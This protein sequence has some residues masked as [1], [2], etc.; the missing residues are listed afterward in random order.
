MNCL[1]ECIKTLFVQH[2]PKVFV[3]QTVFWL[4]S[5]FL[6]NPTLVD[7]AWGANHLVI[8]YSIFSSSGV[9]KAAP[10]G[11]VIGLALLTVWFL[12]L[13]GFIFYNR[14]VKPHVDPR[15]EALRKNRNELVYYFFQFHLQGLLCVFTAIPLY[16]VL[17]KSAMNPLNW[18]GVGMCI[19]GILG[20]ATADQQLQKF[21]NNRKTSTEV[22][23]QGFFKYAR[24]PNLFFELVF[25]TGMTMIGI[26]PLNYCTYVAIL[27][28]TLLWAIM[29]YLTIPVT[30]RHM[31]K[32]KPNYKQIMAETHTFWPFT[33]KH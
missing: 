3:S 5:T 18:L 31:I 16:Y 6:K 13:S 30:T 8:G 4:A 29:Y 24:H 15:Y 10:Y 33:A 19:A 9:L 17:T 7:V 2:Y 21:K 22:F 32:T 25:W 26:S 1:V 11:N 23:R 27:G 20:E 12:R 14:I 28:P